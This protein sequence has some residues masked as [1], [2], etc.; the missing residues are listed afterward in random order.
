MIP[1]ILIKTSKR[2]GNP[3]AFA[4][5]FNPRNAFVLEGA[6][7]FSS[8]RVFDSAGTR[9]PKVNFTIGLRPATRSSAGRLSHHRPSFTT[10]TCWYDVADLVEPL[11]IGTYVVAKGVFPHGLNRDPIAVSVEVVHDLTT[12]GSVNTDD[13]LDAFMAAYYKPP[14]RRVDNGGVRTK[15]TPRDVSKIVTLYP[16]LSA[17]EIARKY[18]ISHVHVYRILRKAGVELRNKSKRSLGD[19]TTIERGPESGP[20]PEPPADPA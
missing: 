10:L 2:T 7:A 20:G 11:P 6:I 15:L 1:E 4:K 13:I 19:Q 14:P 9:T 17:D 18:R 8:R 16:H 5:V 12:V 3:Y